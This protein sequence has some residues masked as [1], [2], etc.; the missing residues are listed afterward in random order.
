MNYLKFSLSIT[1]FLFIFLSFLI[2][3]LSHLKVSLA[4]GKAKA[5]VIATVNNERIT[6]KKFNLKYNEILETTI[7]PPTPQQFLEDL[8]RFEVGI[9]EAQ[10]QRKSAGPKL[11]VEIRKLLYRWLLEEELSQQVQNI[12][13]SEKEMR[14]YYNKNPEIKMS[15]IFLEMRPNAN[16]KQKI[17][18]RKRAKQVYAKV[19]RSKRPFKDLVKLY[20]DDISTKELG[21]DLGWQGRNT[22]IPH[23]Y[24]AAIKQRIG[25]I[26]PL[27]ET[28]YGFHIVKL[29]G[30]NPYDKA[31]KETLHQAVFEDKKRRLFKTYFAGL[32]RRYRIN[33]NQPLMNRLT[34][35]AANR[36]N[37]RRTIASVNKKSITFG[38]FQKEYK[39][40]TNETINP[41][42]R[43]QF[44]DDLIQFEVGVQE[45]E[46]KNISTKFTVQKEM[47]KLLYRWLI[48]KDLGQ[49]VQQIKV[50]KNEMKAH[51]SKNPE[52]RTSHIFIELDPNAK[53]QQRAATKRRATQIYADVKK[54]KRPFEELVKLYTDDS[55]TRETGGDLGWQS[56]NLMIPSYYRAAIRQPIGKIAPLVETQYGFHI[57]KLTGKNSYKNTR[58]EYIRLAIFE[59]KRKRIFDAY[60]AQLKK[61]YRITRNVALLPKDPIRR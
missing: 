49:R 13:V 48:E 16:Q 24:N 47:D 45:A 7:N 54:S 21:G 40:V 17:R 11:Q 37:Y 42:N 31:N 26:A 4:Q 39:K 46:K 32:K 1:S 27:I 59:Q 56:S 36:S 18:Y 57:L 5:K 38:T 60:F 19:K 50:S 43:N 22:M 10:K 58:K 9:Q 33:K 25:G 30:K 3:H 51:Y 34:K 28:K 61:R 15:H 41:P 20:T 53:K 29:V 55:L 12:R 23:Y 14:R 52:I 44:L 2:G 35:K 8:I 6:L